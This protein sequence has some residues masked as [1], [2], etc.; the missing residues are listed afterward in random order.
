MRPRQVS[1]ILLIFLTSPNG[2]NLHFSV[3]KQKRAKNRQQQKLQK[4][5]CQISKNIKQLEFI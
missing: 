1:P 5:Q 3:N 2:P 4:G